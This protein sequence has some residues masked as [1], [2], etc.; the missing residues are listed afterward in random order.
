MY[1]ALLKFKLFICDKVVQMFKNEVQKQNIDVYFKN[2]YPYKPAEQRHLYKIIMAYFT[3]NQGAFELGIPVELI[4]RSS[5]GHNNP[6]VSDTGQ[7]FRIN[8]GI[9]PTGYAE[10]VMAASLLKLN[11]EVEILLNSQ[12]WIHSDFEFLKKL[13]SEILKCDEKSR[14]KKEKKEKIKRKIRL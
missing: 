4:I 12:I 2:D 5:F 7:S 3:A 14:K 1:D 9:I 11:D 6:S 13:N 8:I 10:D